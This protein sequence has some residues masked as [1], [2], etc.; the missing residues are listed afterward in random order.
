MNNEEKIITMLE[1]MKSGMAGVT[2]RLGKMDERLTRMEDET[3]RIALIQENQVAKDIRHVAEG[4]D[5]INERLDRLDL[6]NRLDALENDSDA[7]KAAWSALA[8][9]VARLKR[10]K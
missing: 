10:A 6:E 4:V 3:R 5:V 7:A 9:D 1:E 2:D 8:R